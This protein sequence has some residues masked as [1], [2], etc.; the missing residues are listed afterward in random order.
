MPSASCGACGAPAAVQW[1]RRAGGDPNDV[2]AVYACGEHAISMDAA[3][4]VHAADC[5]APDPKLVPAC[6]CTPEPLPAPEPVEPARTVTL[7]T[8]WVVPASDS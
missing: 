1:Q 6:G 8:G 5:T 3:A 4:Q 2:I 7:D